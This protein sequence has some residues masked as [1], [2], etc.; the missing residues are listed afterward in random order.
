MNAVEQALNLDRLSKIAAVVNLFKSKFPNATADLSPWLITP[1]NQKFEDLDSIDIAFHF[2]RPCVFCCSQSILMQIRL[3]TEGQTSHQRA[4]GIE[5][6]GH[7]CQG[8][9]WRFSTAEK[10]E[11]FG[12]IVPLPPAEMKLKEFCH[13]AVEIFFKSSNHLGHDFNYGDRT[14]T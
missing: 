3:P 6:S 2:P 5:L 9:H 11:F 1:E 12:L 7:D 14:F 10:W 13:G 8:M 4:D